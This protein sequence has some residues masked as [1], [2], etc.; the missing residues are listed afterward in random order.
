MIARILVSEHLEV[1]V[2][3]I[4]EILNQ[5]ELAL[6]HPDVAYF[7]DDQKLG[8]TEAKMIRAH[9]S[10]KPYSAKGRAVVLES[11]HNLTQEAQNA[12]LKTLEEFPQNSII[13]LG[14]E[15]EVNLL[16]TILSRCQI[17]KIRAP[18]GSK[19][20]KLKSKNGFSEEIEKLRTQS[21]EQRF[22]YIE[23]LEEREQFL[24]A[25]VIYYRNKLKEDNSNLEFVKDLLQAE[26]WAAQ[27]VNLRAILEYL[28][29]KLPD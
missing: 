15:T 22:E 4:Q 8:V 18:F 24:E 29:L 16:P 11:A 19:N 9:L 23:K 20:E 12:L 21:V 7:P 26:E 14:V 3:K 27:N 17:I 25:L 28:M 5:S 6:S 2:K 10:L 13:L 1:R